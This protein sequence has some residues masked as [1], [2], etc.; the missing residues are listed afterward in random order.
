[1]PVH[2]RLFA[3]GWLEHV[4]QIGQGDLFPELTFKEDEGYSAA[5]SKWAGRRLRKV[6]IMDKRKVASHSFRHTMATR[7]GSAGVSPQ[8]IDRIQGWA[9][10]SMRANYTHELDARALRDAIEKF[11]AAV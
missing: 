10:D 3:L 5:F 6:G 9:D 2:S 11:T 4:K 8:I 7:L 1:M